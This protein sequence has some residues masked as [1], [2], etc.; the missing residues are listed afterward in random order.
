VVTVAPSDVAG[1]RTIAAPLISADGKTYAC[2][3]NQILSDL[4]VGDGIR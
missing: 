2:R 4:F 3:Y 1:V